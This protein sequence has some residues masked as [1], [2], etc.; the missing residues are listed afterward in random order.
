[1]NEET[2][3]KLKK[4]VVNQSA[5]NDQIIT[6]S[7]QIED[8]LGVYGDDA[9]EFI[10]AFGKEFNVDV[11]KF[12]ANDYF[13]SEGD[14]ILP[15]IIRFF[16]NKKKKEKKSF[17]VGHLEKAIIEGKLDENTFL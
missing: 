7:T 4:F 8:D 5:V 11:S 15:A 2:F 14:F 13:S 3:N 12:M 6:R 9:V 1:M 17:S 10:I 16:T